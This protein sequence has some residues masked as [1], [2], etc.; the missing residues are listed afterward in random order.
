MTAEYHLDMEAFSL[1]EFRHILETERLLP[2]EAI[3]RDRLAE[4]FSTLESMGIRHMADLTAAIKT[5]TKLER[6]AQASGLSKEY[7]VVLRRRA[8][9]YTPRPIPLQKLVGV[10]PEVVERLAAVSVRDTRQLF[11][12]AKSKAGRSA[13][14]REAGVSDD[15]VLEL[16]KLSDLARPP[17][18]GPAFARLL[19]E[20]GVVSIAMLADM[21]AHELH[22]C[23]AEAKARTG[24]YR[25]AL[26]G[27]EDMAA[28]LASVRRLPPAVEY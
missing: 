26:P 15:A 8:G 9:S 10:D 3:L 17:Y 2:S 18:V 22:E 19:Y 1:D 16:T 5:K 27:V 23:L 25:A 28:W 13:L 21:D 7:L 6:F 11:E 12:R 24:V 14:A 20:A 4:R